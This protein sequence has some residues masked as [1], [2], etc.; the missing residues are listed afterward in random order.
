M[1]ASRPGKRQRRPRWV[2]QQ[3]Y[4][5]QKCLAFCRAGELKSKHEMMREMLG[6]MV[7][8]ILSIPCRANP[9]GRLLHAAAVADRAGNWR[10]LEAATR[11]AGGLTMGL[12]S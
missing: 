2:L 9:S 7:S 10:Q 1:V 3:P 5:R 6:D 4:S 8:Q 12:A 11:W